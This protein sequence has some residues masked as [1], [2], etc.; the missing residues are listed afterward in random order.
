MSSRTDANVAR[1]RD[2]QLPGDRNVHYKKRP[3]QAIRAPKA[4]E[5]SNARWRDAIDLQTQT[6]QAHCE[7]KGPTHL[8]PRTFRQDQRRRASLRGRNRERGSSSER[9]RSDTV[10]MAAKRR[11]PLSDI[12]RTGW[13]QPV[14]A[15]FIRPGGVRQVGAQSDR[16]TRNE[17]GRSG[18]VRPIF[19][20]TEISRGIDSGCG[21]S[22]RNRK[23]HND[24]SVH[25]AKA[26]WHRGQRGEGRENARG[27]GDGGGEG[28]GRQKRKRKSEGR[29]R[30]REKEEERGS[31]RGKGKEQRR[32]KGEEGPKKKTDG[33]R[34]TKHPNQNEKKESTKTKNKREKKKTK[35]NH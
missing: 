20:F 21:L 10:R 11:P 12:R 2:R 16:P 1:F 30:K 35:R 29:K 23:P 8:S 15:L 28:K 24:Q 9:C 5:L 19:S 34:A 3:F 18:H 27:D 13:P 31:E 26:G 22:R 32:E 25:Q 4:N 14:D 7:R 33:E 6:K 17:P